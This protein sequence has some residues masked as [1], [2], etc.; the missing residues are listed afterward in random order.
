MPTK[1]LTRKFEEELE[2][3]VEG[4]GNRADV[5]EEAKDA[6]IKISEEFKK[7]ED[8][9][10]KE[11]GDA[12]AETQNDKETLGACPQCNGT[13]KVMYSPLTRKSFVGCSN[14]SKCKACGFTKAACKCACPVCGQSKGKCK[15]GWK[16]KQWAPSCQ[17]IYPLPRGST[18]Y[19]TGKVCDKCKTPIV[20][21]YRRGRRPFSMCLATDCVTKA[22]WEKPKSPRKVRT[23]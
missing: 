8:K 16:E 1:K 9:I 22:D 11:L 23:R 14:Y 13:L 2:K 20:K 3:I 6:V 15:C 5:L 12:I 21:V 18:I 17:A 4:E 10:G 19:K 7:N